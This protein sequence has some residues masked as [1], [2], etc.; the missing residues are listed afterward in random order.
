MFEVSH[1]FCGSLLFF[2][3]NFHNVVLGIIPKKRKQTTS[4][5]F[6][7]VVK[8]SIFILQYY[9]FT[10]REFEKM[11]AQVIVDIS[12]SAVDKVFDYDLGDFSVCVGTRVL[13]PFGSRVIEGI[14]VDKNQNPS[15]DASKIK[16]II[17]PLED[18]PV[19]TSDQFEVME[20]LGKTFHIGR[21]DAL[22]LFLPSEMRQ[23]KVKDLVVREVVL[24]P[25]AESKLADI[26]DRAVKQRE[27]ASY[28]LSTGKD[29]HARLA[30][31]F[32][33]S[34]LK[35]ILQ[36]G[37]ATVQEKVVLRKPYEDLKI[38]RKQVTLTDTQ[39]N[40]VQAITEKPDKYLLFGVTGSGKTEVYM[41]AME[42]AIESGKTGIMLVP[43]ISLTPQTL[44]AF[45]ARFGSTVALLHSGLSSGERFDEWKRILM[46][47]AKIVIGARSAI[48][49]PIK[50]LGLIVVDEEH[51]SSYTSDSN[52]R[53]NTIEV[54]LK[55]GEIAG[56]SVVLGSATPSLESYSRAMNHEYTL[57]EMKDR[58]NKREMPPIKIVDMSHEYR[59]GNTG[60]FSNVLK[61]SL[62]LAI[63]DGKQ[64]MLFIN[65]RGFSSFLM[66]KECGYTAKCDACDVSLVYHKHEKS[67]K[68]H[69]CGNRYRMLD[70]CPECHSKNLKLGSVGT[71]Q[72]VEELQK[73][74]PG[75]KVLRMDND[76]TRTK[77]A[78]QKLVEDFKAG[79][80]QVLVGT[81]MI[82]KGHDFPQVTVVGIVD[83]DISLYQSS[84]LAS[85]RTFALITQV[86]GRAGRADAPG[87]VVLQTNVPRHYIYRL[88]AAYDYTSFFKKEANL[89]EVTN[90]PPYADIIRILFSSESEELVK[91]ATKEYYDAVRE[92]ANEKR[93]DFVYLGVMKSPVGRIQNKFRYQVLMRI[94]KQNAQDII[95]E[96]FALVDKCKKNN[97]SIFVEVNPQSLS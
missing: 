22:R 67:L 76:T 48:F 23:G 74:Y 41:S 47:D 62:D 89:R 24:A 3:Q 42:R 32:G 80:A 65:R 36:K 63:K 91:T 60:I 95:D 70:V 45:R 35:S 2:S 96:L 26:S 81:Q 9:I 93:D 57:I 97:L 58:I 83:A 13:V 75:I 78:H 30:E 92:I 29:N 10:R 68:C 90:F 88:A 31:K 25:D 12:S 84:Y 50:N 4:K 20:F 15:Y 34:A 18:F 7:F 79:K 56:C 69:Y 28:L 5:Y 59:M 40:A 49:A 94:K 11:L 8:Y 52:P 21:A 66:C 77:G 46:G 17:K 61:N 44:A 1:F 27:L 55:R 73:L 87:E 38:E 33:A 37:F 53:Y 43:E 54:A 19:V 16:K 64:A 85:E 72:V 51:D 6:T 39:A 82:V 71:E 86:A 14:V